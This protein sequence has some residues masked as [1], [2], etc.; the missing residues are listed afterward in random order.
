M[1]PKTVVTAIPELATMAANLPPFIGYPEASKLT[2]L[3]V[4]SL[5]RESDAGRLPCYRIG[6]ARVLRVRTADVLALVERVA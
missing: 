1:A 3:S 2:T 5:K 6:R 4:R